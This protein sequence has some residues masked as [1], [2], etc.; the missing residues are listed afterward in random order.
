MEWLSN[1]WNRL[2]TVQSKVS[3]GVDSLQEALEDWQDIDWAMYKLAQS[4]GV[5]GPDENFQVDT[6]HM[7]WTNHPVGNVMFD[8]LQCLEDNGIV[9]CRDDKESG[10]QYRFCNQVRSWCG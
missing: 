1:L 7:W 8:L 10:L 6:K 2:W 5:I 4:L 9:E 3:F